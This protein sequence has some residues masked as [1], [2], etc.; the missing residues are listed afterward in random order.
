MARNIFNFIAYVCIN[1]FD[2]ILFNYFSRNYALNCRIS[3]KM[4]IM[5]FMTILISP[6]FILW[7]YTVTI[8]SKFELLYSQYVA[9]PSDSL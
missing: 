7:G 4:D 3:S 6:I 8:D 5:I 2:H 9:Q 1:Y